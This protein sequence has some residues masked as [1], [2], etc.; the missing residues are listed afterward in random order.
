MHTFSS[1][2]LLY[3]C[4]IVSTSPPSKKQKLP[5]SPSLPSSPESSS[6][7]ELPSSQDLDSTIVFCLNTGEQI[8]ASLG[9]QSSPIQQ[10]IDGTQS[11]LL[12]CDWIEQQNLMLAA[13]I[14]AETRV[15]PRTVA[16]NPPAAITRNRRPLFEL[17]YQRVLA[18][19][20][21]NAVALIQNT[22]NNNVHRGTECEQ[23]GLSCGAMVISQRATPASLYLIT[24]VNPIGPFRAW[25]GL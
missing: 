7:I 17:I 8:H 15:T 10:G 24:T 23:N 5:E 3:I 21:D 13:Q 1:H 14:R 2:V 18:N 19:T 16:P 9:L 22:V 20:K 4:F 11:Y 25:A 6:S 12:L